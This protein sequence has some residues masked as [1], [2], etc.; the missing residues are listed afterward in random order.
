M[1]LNIHLIGLLY[2]GIY[3]GEKIKRFQKMENYFKLYQ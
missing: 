2:V 3:K 1:E